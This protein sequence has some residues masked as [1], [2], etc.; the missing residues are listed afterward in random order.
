MHEES[1]GAFESHV[2]QVV[3]FKEPTVNIQ[4]DQH[5]HLHRSSVHVCIQAELQEITSI[6]EATPP[7]ADLD[8]SFLNSANRKSV[9]WSYISHRSLNNFLFL[10]ND[11]SSLTDRVF[12]IGLQTYV[13]NGIGVVLKMSSNV[14]NIWSSSVLQQKTD[15]LPKVNVH[16]FWVNENTGNLSHGSS[17]KVSISTLLPSYL[18]FVHLVMWGCTLLSTARTRINFELNSRFVI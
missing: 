4:A 5:K 10:C 17:M 1:T 11:R 8:F 18:W 12:T 9:L 14:Y 15:I 13:Q 3:S 6:V 16:N 7:T 2:Q